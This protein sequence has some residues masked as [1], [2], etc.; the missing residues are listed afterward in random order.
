MLSLIHRHISYRQCCFCDF[1]YFFLF[2]Y[3]QQKKKFKL[4]PSLDQSQS[5][6][7]FVHQEMWISSQAGSTTWVAKSKYTLTK[8][9]DWLVDISP[10]DWDTKWSTTSSSWSSSPSVPLNWDTMWRTG[11]PRLCLKSRTS[12]CNKTFLFKTLTTFSSLTI[13]HRPQPTISPL[14]PTLQSQSQSQGSFV[15]YF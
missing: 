9:H 14:N 15:V 10:L 12:A 3:S 4:S 5:L 8:P 6:Y 7:Y 11:G 2:V 13:Y 1:F